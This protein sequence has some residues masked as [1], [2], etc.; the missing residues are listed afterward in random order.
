[1]QTCLK[2]T[3]SIFISS[4]WF[5]LEEDWRHF[6]DVIL[7]VYL[8]EQLSACSLLVFPFSPQKLQVEKHTVM[9]IYDLNF[10]TWLNF[11]VLRCF[12]K[13]EVTLPM[14]RHIYW[15]IRP[16]KRRQ[17][18][19]PQAAR[20]QLAGCPTALSPFDSD[21]CSFVPFNLFLACLDVVHCSLPF[22]IT[23][24]LICLATFDKKYDHFISSETK[25][26]A[27]TLY[28]TGFLVFIYFFSFASQHFCTNQQQFRI[29]VW[30]VAD[31]CLFLNKAKLFYFCQQ[32]LHWVNAHV[33]VFARIVFLLLY[34]FFSQFFPEPFSDGLCWLCR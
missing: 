4:Q 12:F 32:N 9:L 1:M 26:H 14:R 8:N 3:L 33:A 18:A 30:P 7:P 19:V 23:F 2:K 20:F 29:F 13:A 16:E 6:F 25:Q 17:S 27:V 31:V 15:S 10:L 34:A 22:N 11:W 28:L 21:S 5:T 24:S